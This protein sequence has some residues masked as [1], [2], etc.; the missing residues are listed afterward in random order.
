MGVTRNREVT[1]NN[2]AEKDEALKVRLAKIG[3]SQKHPGI[4]LGYRF[5]HGM[6]LPTDL[7]SPTW[8]VLKLGREM[9]DEEK[10][11]T[12]Q[13]VHL[14]WKLF[15]DFRECLEDLNH[16]HPYFDDPAES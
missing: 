13:V 2:L 3:F 1:D 14:I 6:Q 11:L 15:C 8:V 4:T 16:D 7:D 5:F 10:P 9:L 12:K